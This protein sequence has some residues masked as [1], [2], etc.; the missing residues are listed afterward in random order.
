M[1]ERDPYAFETF[2]H[3]DLLLPIGRR[4]ALL[5]AVTESRVREGQQQGGNAFK[6]ASLGSLPDELIA[7]LTPRLAAGCTIRDDG[8][9]VVADIEGRDPVALFPIGLPASQVVARFDGR[10]MVE[11]IAATLAAEQEWDHERALRYVRG[12]FLHLIT[13]GVCWPS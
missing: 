2:P 12:V 10:T 3:G 6:L 5:T 4:Q 7:L 13:L 9:F 11:S 8:R 1:T